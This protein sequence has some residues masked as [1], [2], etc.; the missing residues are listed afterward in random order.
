M[1]PHKLINYK[2][3]S[4]C[5][6]AQINFLPLEHVLFAAY[7]VLFAWLVT[8]V[9]FFATSGL[10][11]AQLIIIFLLK[12]MAGIFYG[13]I[14]VYYG[15]LAQ[16]VD[17]WQFHY[18]SLKEYD[19]L[20]TDPLAFFS[21]LFHS[22][23]AEG[24]GGFLATENSWW[25]DLKGTSFIKFLSILNLLSFGNYYV[26]VIFF[27]FITL[28]GPVA[29][30]RVMRSVFPASTFSIMVATFLIPSFLYW[31]SGIHKDGLIFLGYS[32]IAYSFY[33]GF[34]EGFFTARKIVC[35][36]L[37]FLLVLVLRNF[38]IINLLPALLAWGLVQKW[39]QR[40]LV[41]F[42]VVYLIFIF[43]FFIARYLHPNLDFPEA[44]VER[45][46]AFMKLRGGSAVEVTHLQPSFASFV[47]NFPQAIS[48]TALRPFP[49]DVR[50]LLSLAAFL[51][52]FSLLLLFLMF[53]IW[54]R[55]GKNRDPFLLFCL[56]LSFSVLLMIGY[57]VNFLGA[58]VRYRSI[59]LPFLIVPM[60]ALT[61]WPKI[62][63]FVN[64][65]II[66]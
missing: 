40:P 55:P 11:P 31:T 24:Y 28:F 2:L 44:V 15:E 60:V 23:Y 20:K 37:G 27:S 13:W 52:I 42:S 33:F 61:N 4:S 21:N 35:I 18:E 30:Y 46:Q 38:L 6:F 58:I 53:I 16:M 43:L 66:K 41:T 29:L 19:L 8:K 59:I 5:Y 64:K 1:Q 32:L 48:L 63:S 47:H 10:T 39:K 54:L 34:K 3:I 49:S 45:Q 7:L 25:N 14:G 17:T 9:R 51:E 50:H 62:L 57:S 22:P 12:V 56:F 26:N 65:H 36:V